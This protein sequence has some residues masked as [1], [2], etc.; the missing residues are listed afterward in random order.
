MKMTKICLI[1]PA[2]AAEVVGLPV[3][4]EGGRGHLVTGDN[5]TRDRCVTTEG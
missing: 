3:K 2:G 1:M 4:D 5:D